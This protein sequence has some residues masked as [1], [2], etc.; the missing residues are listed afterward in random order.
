MKLIISCIVINALLL[1]LL[2][3]HTQAG[4][5]AHIRFYKAN[6][7]LQEDRIMFTRKKAR[8]AG[9]HNFL[10]SVRI[11]R[12]NQIGFKQCQ[13]FAKKDC[14]TDSLLGVKDDDN[15]TSQIITQG[16][17]WFPSGKDERGIK[18]KSWQ[19]EEL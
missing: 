8:A 11:Y 13:L 14:K 2:T 10:K 7:L 1:A 12:I 6:K 5:R 15:A 19:C 3:S 18:A 4:P 17:S 16:V 9:C